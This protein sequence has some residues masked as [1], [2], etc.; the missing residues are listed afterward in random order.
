VKLLTDYDSLIPIVFPKL[1]TSILR[2]CCYKWPWGTDSN[3]K[4]SM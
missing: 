3:V 4:D 1:N 2:N